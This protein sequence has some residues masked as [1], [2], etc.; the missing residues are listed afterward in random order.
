MQELADKNYGGSQTHHT[1]LDIRDLAAGIYE[2]QI[3]GDDRIQGARL[4]KE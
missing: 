3:Y 2:L 4:V 1:Q